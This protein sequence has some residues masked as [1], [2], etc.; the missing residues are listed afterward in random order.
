MS[1]PGR[2]LPIAAVQGRSRYANRMR[3]HPAM[4][5]H[6]PSRLLGRSNGGFTQEAAVQFA[7]LNVVSSA[8]AEVQV[9][10]L[11]RQL[12]VAFTTLPTLCIKEPAGTDRQNQPVEPYYEESII[13]T[14]QIH[15]GS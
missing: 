15:D 2:V 1:L 10:P 8:F 3:R 7:T 6:S 14:D 11:V 13:R 9:S 5:R 4:K 12:L